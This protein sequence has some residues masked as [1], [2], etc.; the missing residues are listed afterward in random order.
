[1]IVSYLPQYEERGEHVQ[2]HKHQVKRIKVILLAVK[3]NVSSHAVVPR[4]TTKHTPHNKTSLGLCSLTHR[5]DMRAA[6]LVALTLASG[7]PQKG[8]R[9]SGSC[10]VNCTWRL[11]SRALYLEKMWQGSKERCEVHRKKKETWQT[12]DGTRKQ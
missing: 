7:K 9:R 2:Q 11:G 8:V 4:P 5:A 1:M 10:A 12:C 3:V 6:A